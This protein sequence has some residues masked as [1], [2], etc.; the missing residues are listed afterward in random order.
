MDAIVVHGNER[1]DA[2][3]LD[4]VPPAV[5]QRDG[6]AGRGE[7][8]REGK[9]LHDTSV[10][11]GS[12]SD[13]SRECRPPD[14]PAPPYRRGT[15]T[16]SQCGVF[17]SVAQS[18][19]RSTETP[20]SAVTVP[21]KARSASTVCMQRSQRMS[22]SQS[23]LARAV[24][25]TLVELSPVSLNVPPAATCEAAYGSTGRVPATRRSRVYG[26]DSGRKSRRP[27]PTAPAA[28]R[29]GSAPGPRSSRR[30]V[31]V[32]RRTGRASPPRIG[33]CWLQTDH[34]DVTK[35]LTH[36]QPPRVGSGS[37]NRGEVGRRGSPACPAL[38]V[39]DVAEHGSTTTRQ[40]AN[41]SSGRTSRLGTTTKRCQRGPLRDE[42]AAPGGR[43][44][45]WGS[46]VEPEG[47]R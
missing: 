25:K 43:R 39:H 16:S 27:A 6:V 1:A 2:V 8:R 40:Q 36:D 19:H 23:E 30:S 46:P 14:G 17:G 13:T 15:P 24:M 37:E 5:T 34:L 22:P 12:E 21:T 45:G 31:D 28:G 7:H 38:P 47:K 18:G 29:S 11:H 4:L 10:P 32:P 41:T 20:W 9:L 33:E 26:A 42:V 3:P 35:L 44:G